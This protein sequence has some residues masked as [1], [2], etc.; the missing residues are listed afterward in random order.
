MA[1]KSSKRKTQQQMKRFISF[2]LF[3]AIVLL[4]LVVRS[5]ASA[6]STFISTLAE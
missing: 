6:L 3:A 5:Y 4:T 1:G 2:S